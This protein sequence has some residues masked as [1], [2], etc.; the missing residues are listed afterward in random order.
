[1]AFAVFGVLLA[2]K[3]TIVWLT[4]ATEPTDRQRLFYASIN[5]SSVKPTGVRSDYVKSAV[6]QIMRGISV[7]AVLSV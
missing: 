5:N 2:C 1:M 7:R 4:L 3:L 6:G